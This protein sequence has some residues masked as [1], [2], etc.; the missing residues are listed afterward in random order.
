MKR[1]LHGLLLALALGLGLDA[2]T[3]AESVPALRAAA[4]V[5]GDG[6]FSTDL[7]DGVPGLARVR[8]TNAPSPGAAVLVSREDVLSALSLAGAALNPTNWTGPS[9]VRVSRRIRDLDEKEVRDL[10]T[11]ELQRRFSRDRGELELRMSR[12]WR[13]LPVADENFELRLVEA[14]AQG[15]SPVSL[16][17]QL[18][19]GDEVLGEWFQPVSAK[20][21][22]DVFV[23]PTPVRRGAAL[24]DAEIT[25]ERRDLL[26]ARDSVLQ[27]PDNAAAWEF[28]ESL[29]SGQVLT[30]R[31]LRLRTVVARG[32][33]IDAVVRS[34]P[35]EITAKVEALEDGVPGQVIRVR[36]TQSRRELRGRVESDNTVLIA[37]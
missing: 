8:V 10:L 37:L 2:A 36:N 31:S 20:L 22:A 23:A 5:R 9:A 14:P 13:T 29:N 28:A 18:H 30:K 25:R 21:W 16:R 17:F 33:L 24:P 27:L 19:A 1:L 7:I 35:M 3:A 6:V 12:P 15:L 26:T 32:R 34:G 11:A 4:L